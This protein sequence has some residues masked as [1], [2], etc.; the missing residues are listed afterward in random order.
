MGKYLKFRGRP[1]P[2]RLTLELHAMA[3]TSSLPMAFYSQHAYYPSPTQQH[4]LPQQESQDLPEPSNRK[5]SVKNCPIVLDSDYNGKMC[6]E[7]RGR[8]RIYASTKRAKRK[9][10]KLAAS[11]GDGTPVFL[12]HD[13]PPVDADVHSAEPQP[14]ESH[15]DE[16]RDELSVR[17]DSYSSHPVRASSP[18]RLILPSKRQNR[19]RLHGRHKLTRDCSI[20]PCHRPLLN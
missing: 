14:P 6:Q 9:M 17:S 7:C 12:P 8:H 4:A 19:T 2:T 11:G 20:N 3:S 15:P 16:V 1:S 13:G 18:F 5:C 10:E